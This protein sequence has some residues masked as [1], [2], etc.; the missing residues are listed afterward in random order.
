M[1]SYE[2]VFKRELD[3][4]AILA[5]QYNEGKA[6]GK[7]EKAIELVKNM[8]SASKKTKRDRSRSN[9]SFEHDMINKRQVLGQLIQEINHK[10]S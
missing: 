5:K 7:E 8:L 4:K 2:A 10:S 9:K 3:H 1:L 6:K